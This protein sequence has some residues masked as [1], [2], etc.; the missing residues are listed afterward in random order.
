ML[1]LLLAKKNFKLIFGLGVILLPTF[2]SAQFA[3]EGPIPAIT[4]GYGSFGNDSV[5][6]EFFSIPPDTLLECNDTVKGIIS[7]PFYAN[8]ALPVVFNFPGGSF[9]DV[10]DSNY[11]RSQQFY[12]EFVASN[13]YVAATAPYYSGSP[14]DEGCAYHW[15][16][17]LIK[18]RSSLIDSTRMGMR[19]YSLGAGVANWLALTQYNDRNW[20]SNGRF[21]WPD[22]GASFT[23]FRTNWPKDIYRQTDSG[24]AAM[25]DDVL[26]LMTMHDFDQVC[27]PRTGI[28]MF[29]FIGVPDT[30]KAF[31]VIKG[32]TVNNYIYWATHF[33]QSTF[34]HDSA[35]FY[36]YLTKHDALDYWFGTRLLHALMETAWGADPIAR[37]ICLGDND[38]IQMN[39]ANGQLRSPI[40]SD[41]PWMTMFH[42]WNNGNG[43]S[44]PCTVQWNMRQYVTADACFTLDIPEITKQ[45]SIK[46][47][48]NPVV[49]NE[50]IILES[51]KEIESIEVFNLLGRKVLTSKSSIFKVTLPG[52]YV[53]GMQF[54]DGT[55]K[56]L[57][58]IVN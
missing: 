50:E 9:E 58:F 37:R 21:V 12:Q 11:F 23:G 47:Y 46:L 56:A 6:H 41:T 49:H 57:R 29:N 25:P 35:Q 17:S 51:E 24:L 19:G 38:S 28:D 44:S 43:Y 3:F 13:G 26:Y 45:S 40:V 30:N 42:S 33:T 16:E 52:T 27:D 53:L 36:T 15:T 8:G 2:S 31:Y 1:S 7:Y 20:G 14:S 54:S 22:A 18:N 48:P 39:W 32:D 4:S 55:T 34:A 5:I 10:N